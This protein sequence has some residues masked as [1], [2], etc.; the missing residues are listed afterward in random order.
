MALAPLARD[1]FGVR[2]QNPIVLASGTAGYGR[3]LDGVMELDRLGGLVT[4][5]VSLQPRVGNAPPR[6]AEFRGGMLN[7]VGLAN[8]G[9]AHVRTAEMPWL[10]GRLRAA[11]VLV[12]VVGF[13]LEEY[14]AVI[15][16]LD[17]LDG[18]TAYE[19]NLSC[20]NTAAGGIEFGADPASVSA[21]IARCRRVTKRPL[22]AKLSPVLPDIAGMAVVARD[23]GADGVSVVNTLPGLALDP[24]GVPRLGNGNGGASGPALL[25]A[26]VLAVRR[27][28]ERAADL[29]VIGL[30]GVRSADD[31]RQYLAAGASLVGIGTGGM[32]DPRLPGRIIRDLERRHG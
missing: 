23:A 20:P 31:A 29:P 24:H 28:R 19:L 27:V 7:S 9:L 32:A 25:P 21:V 26:G 18:I 5:A 2:F 1:V 16:G 13:T 8:P 3:E 11:R 12:N 22:V 17:D 4:K 10:L 6:V 14:A 30:G 15:E